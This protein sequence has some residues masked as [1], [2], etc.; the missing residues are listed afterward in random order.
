MITNISL[1]LVLFIFIS[2]AISESG[3]EY[4]FVQLTVNGKVYSAMKQDK[5]MVTNPVPLMDWLANQSLPEVAISPIC[6]C[7]V[8]DL[9][10]GFGLPPWR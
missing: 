9:R 4:C 1:N 8:G 2:C 10:P 5:G 3:R 7:L 6:P